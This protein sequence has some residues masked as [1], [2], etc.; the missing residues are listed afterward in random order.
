M[1][2]I[3]LKYAVPIGLHLEDCTSSSYIICD[4]IIY[5]HQTRMR[6]RHDM[7]Q[8]R[9]GAMKSIYYSYIIYVTYII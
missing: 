4:Y 9:E 2:R 5:A 1:I 6:K 7:L 3:A 8:S